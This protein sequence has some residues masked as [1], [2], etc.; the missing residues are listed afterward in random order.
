[1]F[2]LPLKPHITNG[3]R[4]SCGARATVWEN[5]TAMRA[6]FRTTSADCGCDLDHTL[7]EAPRCSRKPNLRGKPLPQFPVRTIGRHAAY[8]E[9]SPVPL[10][11][12]LACSLLLRAAL[13]SL[14]SMTLTSRSRPREWELLDQSLRQTVFLFGPLR[15][16]CTEHSARTECVAVV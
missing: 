9:S 14:F 10:C 11:C 5:P 12:R 16:R 4:S 1:V 6:G 15:P 3:P 13:A 7:G 2:V 8:T